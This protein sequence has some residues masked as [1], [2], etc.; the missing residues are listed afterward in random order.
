VPITDLTVAPT[1]Q[2]VRMS[3]EPAA[4]PDRPQLPAERPMTDALS[5]SPII[6]GYDGSPAAEAALRFA[7]GLAATAADEVIAAAVYQTV[8]YVLAVGASDAADAEITVALRAEALEVLEG[9]RD[10]DVRKE[11]VPGDSP[12]EGLHRLARRRQARLIAVGVTHR[13]AI[14]RLLVGGVGDRL[15]HGASCPVAVVPAGWDGQGFATV[16]VGF[17]GRP[18]P[19]PPSGPRTTWRRDW[20]PGSRSSA[21]TSPRCTSG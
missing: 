21:S 4:L 8:P 11:A 18:S 12:A 3:S 15:L 5:S 2:A 6:A 16:G 10:D 7:K 1:M 14:G 13:A 19:G 9:L 17:D 20:A